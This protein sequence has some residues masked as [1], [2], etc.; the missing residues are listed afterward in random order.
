MTGA[1][2]KS[3]TTCLPAGRRQQ[4]GRAL[5]VGQLQ[6]VP[7]SAHDRLPASRLAFYNEWQ[8]ALSQDD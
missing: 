2:S 7:D 4:R 1:P 5:E 8:R 6:A 3:D